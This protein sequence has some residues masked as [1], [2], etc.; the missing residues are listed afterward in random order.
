MRRDLFVSAL[1]SAGNDIVEATSEIDHVEA[2]QDGDIAIF[3]IEAAD[4]I[5]PQIRR[6]LERK[7]SLAAVVVC[8]EA[9]L[10]DARRELG[11]VVSALV[12]EALNLDAI[13]GSIVLVDQG[14]R[15]VR[16]GNPNGAKSPLAAAGTHDASRDPVP[17]VRFSKREMAVLNYLRDGISNKDIAN[18]MGISDAT[19]KV[20]LR[21]VFRKAR[22]KN[23]TQA[24]IW[25]G[26]HLDQLARHVSTD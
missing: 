1:K 5:I 8:P 7:P 11:D 6:L 19:V 10:E 2:A 13:V 16:E 17:D 26:K 9:V 18:R 25:A 21:S 3:W 20:H 14:Y 22:V 24:A 15:L 4:E 12:P 23:R